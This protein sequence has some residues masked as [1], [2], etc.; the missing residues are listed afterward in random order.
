[1]NTIEKYAKPL[2][3]RLKIG[4]KNY[5]EKI[6]KN[7][8]LSIKIFTDVSQYQRLIEVHRINTFYYEDDFCFL[9]MSS[10]KLIH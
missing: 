9:L 7:N 1:M 2:L 5:L 4:G 8:Q 3:Y 10:K 6:N